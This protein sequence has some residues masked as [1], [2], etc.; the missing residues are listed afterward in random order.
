MA[1]SSAL[2]AALALVAGATA[3]PNPAV[4]GPQLPAHELL[5]RQSYTSSSTGTQ[6][7]FYYSFWTSG[8]SGVTYTN[9]AGGEYSVTWGSSS[10]NFVGGK[11]WNPWTPA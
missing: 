5:R 4:E 9:G 7:G 2:L 10:Q 3:L 11:G 8:G 1:I 6:N